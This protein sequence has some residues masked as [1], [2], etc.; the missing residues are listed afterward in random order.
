MK[1]FEVRSLP[2]IAPVECPCGF[3]KRAF[4]ELPEQTLTAPERIG[5]TAVEWGGSEIK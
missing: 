4:T 3:T 1:R 5:F 2:E